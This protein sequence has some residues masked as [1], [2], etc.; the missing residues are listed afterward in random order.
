MAQLDACPTCD[1]EVMDATPIGSAT[2]FHGVHE[3]F[4]SHSLPSADSRRAV[5]R[6]GRKM[7]NTG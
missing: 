7:H 6:F 1:Q 3:I 4:A 5:V 2:F